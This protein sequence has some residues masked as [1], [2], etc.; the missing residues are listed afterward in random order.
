[1]AVSGSFTPGT[2]FFTGTDQLIQAGL[3]YQS[4]RVTGTAEFSG[5][6]ALTK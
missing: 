3:G 1:M 5:T 2:T 6:T 4:I